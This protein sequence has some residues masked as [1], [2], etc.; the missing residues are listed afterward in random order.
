VSPFSM[1]APEP[2]NSMHRLSALPQE[3]GRFQLLY[4]HG[5]GSV[6]FYL[7]TLSVSPRCQGKGYG[8]QLIEAWCDRA[9]KLGPSLYRTTSRGEPSGG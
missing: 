2:E 6:E 4:P 5:T 3:V 7:D 1:T 8:H 9:R